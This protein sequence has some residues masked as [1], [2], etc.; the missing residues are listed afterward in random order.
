M[1]VRTNGGSP[2]SGYFEILEDTLLGFFLPAFSHSIRKTQTKAPKFYFI[3]TGIKRALSKTL[4]IEL[5]PHTYGFG[6]AFE[7]WVILEIIKNASYKRWDWTYSYLRTKDNV[8]ID[9]II[10]K[11]KG[12]LMI[13]IKSGDQN[14]K[15]KSTFFRKTWP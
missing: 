13:E 8:E 7:H 2:V 4:T 11:P 9:L 15:R 3:D 5:P 12:L 10:H 6:E 14:D 1:T